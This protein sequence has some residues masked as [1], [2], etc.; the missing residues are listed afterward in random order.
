MGIA[1]RVRRLLYLLRRSRHDADLR[2]EMETHRSL[3][4]ETLERDGVAPA[5]AAAESRRAL[6]NVTLARED[7]RQ[8]WLAPAIES[9]GQ[10]VR[11]GLR[12]LRR[13]RA[14]T[15]VALAMLAVGIG[16][17]TS[18][19]GVVN[20]LL[21]RPWPVGDP[22]R[23]VA[24]G[25]PNGTITAANTSAA[26]YRFLRDEAQTI[27][28][29]A[30]LDARVRIGHEVGAE[31]VEAR[32]VSGNYFSALRM[33][34]AL[35]RGFRADEDEVGHPAAVAVIS[36]GVWGRMFGHSRDVLG[37]AL[38]ANG[39]SFTIVGVAARGATDSHLSRPDVWL[40]L[41]ALPLLST[42]HE[43]GRR[44]L[45]DPEY[46]CVRLAGR[47]RTNASPSMAAAELNAL[48]AQF[49]SSGDDRAALR[50]AVTGTYG[51]V[52]AE[53]RQW[54]QMGTLVFAGMLLLVAAA[55]ANI[56]NLQLARALARRRELAIR[57][58]LGAGRRRIIRQLLTE[59]VVM[60]VA[61]A[62]IAVAGTFVLPPIM[63][64]AVRPVD[65]D[66]SPDLRVVLCAIGVALFSVIVAS[67]APALRGTHRLTFDSVTPV[68]RLRLRSWLLAVQVT[69]STV[70]IVAAA[71]LFRGVVRA[72]TFDPGYAIDDVARVSIRVPDADSTRR[73][74]LMGIIREGLTGIVPFAEARWMPL[75]TSRSSID[76]RR[77][78]GTEDNVRVAR[79]QHVSAAYFDVLRIPVLS[80][81]VFVNAARSDEVVVNERLARALR[82]DGSAAGQ[83]IEADGRWR[84]AGVVADAHVS[85]LERIEP[86]LFMPLTASDPTPA[87]AQLLVPADPGSVERVRA[88]VVSAEPTAIVTVV[89]LGDDRRRVLRPAKVGAGLA[90]ALG[91]LAVSLA[92]IGICGVFSYVVEARTREI[93]VRVAL[94]ARA[95]QVVGLVFRQAAWPLTGGLATGLTVSALGAPVLRS[96]L[97]GV[98]PYDPLAFAGAAIIAVVAAAIATFVPGR[99]AAS[100][101]PAA[102][103]RHD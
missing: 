85:S 95:P 103:L 49:R 15:V 69:T 68:D 67:L 6:G 91:I 64:A 43:P 92:A 29:V 46:C 93:G 62:A 78:D 101:D 31:S 56:G 57:Y 20:G 11:Y 73:A 22:G 65:T 3:R 32:H 82:P 8:V 17:T 34:V 38:H 96:Y 90:A 55:S 44:F 39:V 28:L 74:T 83:W 53:G 71:L 77:A 79:V 16:A 51:V 97:I 76:V 4:Q 1:T 80:G 2:E 86:T 59:G 9:L 13:S 89:P 87:T 14:F 84:V 21:L 26:E 24:V 70:L 41:A 27:D 18:V 72:A 98:G 66:L 54:M 100:I 33:P 30:T 50:L 63:L 36:D 10:D 47:L 40:P 58:A 88:L 48:D 25:P 75:S 99:R 5:D 61:A 35:G 37:Q 52:D 94:G 19:F 102:V 12:S 42:D 60:G 7:A 81:H 23:V 45:N